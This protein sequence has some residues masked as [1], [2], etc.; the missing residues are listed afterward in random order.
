MHKEC[1]ISSLADFLQVPPDRLDECLADFKT[2]LALARQADEVSRISSGVLKAEVKF[3]LR[4]F[5]WVDDGSRGVS[6]IDVATTD[7]QHIGR[8]KEPQ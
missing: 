2:W 3:D 8:I 7:G 5:T 6:G 4:A 1:R